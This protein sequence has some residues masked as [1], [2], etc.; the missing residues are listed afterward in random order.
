M[1]VP[2]GRLSPVSSAVESAVQ[3]DDPLLEPHRV[4]A[5]RLTIDSGGGLLLQS[6]ETF[7]Q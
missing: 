2:L 4:V 1:Y 6:E 5:P 3:I 7:L